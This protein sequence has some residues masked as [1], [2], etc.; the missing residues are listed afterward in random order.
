[1]KPSIGN[2]DTLVV[3]LVAVSALGLYSIAGSSGPLQEVMQGP[4]ENV[5]MYEGV[6][7]R[8]Y[9]NDE[10]VTETSNTLMEGHVAIENMVTGSDTH[11]WDTIA[12]G[13]GTTPSKGDNTLDSEWSSCGLSP[14]SS[15]I[16][17]DV[18]TSGKWNLTATFDST[19]DNIIVNTT[20]QKSKNAA[21][22]EDY[23]AGAWLE[24]DINLYSGDSLTIEWS[25]EVT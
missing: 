3:A 15:S 20:A 17:G 22:S 11:V 7:V 8:V 24:R 13:N 16:D 2:I 12:V 19:C 25:N 5:E 6:N 14:A 18:S 10:L 1:M 23:F 9:K 4:S 21:T